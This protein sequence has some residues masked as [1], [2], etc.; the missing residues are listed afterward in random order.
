[1]GIKG[2]IRGS[3]MRMYWGG[4]VGLGVGTCRR[5]GTDHRVRLVV[6]E[7]RVGKGTG[8]VHSVLFGVV[9]MSG[10]HIHTNL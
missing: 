4:S 1:M 10:I 5:G 2:R 9:F 7:M 6:F 3:R 8:V